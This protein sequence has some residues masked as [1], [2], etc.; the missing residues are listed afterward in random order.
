LL[1]R[2]RESERLWDELERLV[3]QYGLPGRT[4]LALSD[5]A[6]GLR[7]RN[8]TYR[9][10]IGE[11][12]EITEQTATRDLARLVDVGLLKPHGEKRGRFYVRDTALADMWRA[13]VEARGR[14]DD[15]DPFAPAG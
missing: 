11:L 1:R 4:I 12:G 6:I 8:G 2:V 7:V 3:G 14:R 5:A 13:I 9:A 10:A 15:S